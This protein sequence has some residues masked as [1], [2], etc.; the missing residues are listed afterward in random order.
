MVILAATAG[1]V[2]VK[3]GPKEGSGPGQTPQPVHLRAVVGL[4]WRTVVMWMVFLALLSL[5]RLHYAYHIKPGGGVGTLGIGIY[6]GLTSRALGNDWIAVDPVSDDD[7][8]VKHR[9][10]VFQNQRRD[11][12]QRVLLAQAVG[13]AQG[14]GIDH[15]DLLGHTQHAQGHG[16]LAAKR[17][18]R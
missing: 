5:A 6:G 3:L 9:L 8:G 12:A 18:G 17:S 14:V 7:A 13:G 1:A 4:V 16:N 15:R 11:F 2:N 10:T